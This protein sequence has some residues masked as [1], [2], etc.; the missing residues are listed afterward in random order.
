MLTIL[1]LG[2]PPQRQDNTW[3][4]SWPKF[5]AE[6]RIGDLVNRIH[7]SHPDPELRKLEQ[8]MRD[9]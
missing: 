8:Q 5:W 6:R 3:E 2:P 9:R 4:V 1:I 7:A